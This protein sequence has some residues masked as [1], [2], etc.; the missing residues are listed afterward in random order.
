MIIRAIHSHLCVPLGQ[1]YIAHQ[2]AELY[3]QPR[4]H[5]QEGAVSDAKAAQM[6]LQVEKHRGDVLESADLALSK[7]KAK[8]KSTRSAVQVSGFRVQG[9][10]P[11]SR[12]RQAA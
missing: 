7:A 1:L 6:V 9:T 8:L 5:Q 11:P 2:L 10:N 12:S 4:H 3:R